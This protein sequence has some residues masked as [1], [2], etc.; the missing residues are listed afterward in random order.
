MCPFPTTITITPRACPQK[1]CVYSIPCCCGKIYKGDTGRQLKVRREEHR[2]AVV[3]GEIE[4]S[5]MADHI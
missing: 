1:N 3:C 5:G 2:R 4:K